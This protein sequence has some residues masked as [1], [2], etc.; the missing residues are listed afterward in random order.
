VHISASLR[1]TISFVIL[2]FCTPDTQLDLTSALVPTGSYHRHHLDWQT[3]IQRLPYT[4]T[5][6][7]AK[8]TLVVRT[9]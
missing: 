7:P 9:S 8:P 1:H 6:L 5:L 4:F 3:V 2:L